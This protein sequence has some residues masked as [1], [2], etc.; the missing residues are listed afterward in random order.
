MMHVAVVTGMHVG[1][2]DRQNLGS[3]EDDIG[4]IVDRIE[5]LAILVT[6]AADGQGLIG[7]A[8]GEQRFGTG[9]G[10][11]YMIGTMQEEVADQ[12]YRPASAIVLC[13]GAI[14]FCQSAR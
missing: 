4:H 13:L 1:V 6:G 10:Q 7:A 5:H 8:T 2:A 14:Q 3:L 11:W 9:G 12:F